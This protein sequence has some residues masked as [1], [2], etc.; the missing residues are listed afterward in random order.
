MLDMYTKGELLVPVFLEEG[1]T[2][3]RYSETCCA[4]AASRGLH[5]LAWGN[6]SQA[7]GVEYLVSFSFPFHAAGWEATVLQA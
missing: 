2:T 3:W 5:F 4:W 7:F 6:L 1:D